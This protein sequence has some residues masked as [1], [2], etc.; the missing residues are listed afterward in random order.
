MNGG[1]G[2]MQNEM[3]SKAKPSVPNVFMSRLGHME[4][5]SPDHAEAWPTYLERLQFYFTA[6]GVVEE[7]HQRVV[8]QLLRSSYLNGAPVSKSSSGE[9]Q[10]AVL[11]QS[12]VVTSVET[13]L[14]DYSDVFKPGLGKSTGLPVR[15]EVEEQATPKFHKSRQVP[16]AL[17]PKVDEAIEKL[18]EQ[19]IYVPI[20]RSRWATPIVPILEER[21]DKNLRRLQGNTQPSCQVEDLPTAH[22]RATAR[23]TGRLFSGRLFSVT[24]HKGLF[25]VT[26]LQ[27]GVAVAVAIFQRYMEGLLNGLEGVQCFLDY[28][29]IGGRTAADHDERLR[30]VLQRNQDDGLRLNADKCAFRDNEVT[31]LGYRINKG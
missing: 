20:K 17:L 15:I 7:K 26:R 28:I 13:P 21:E 19:G 14:G 10:P 27:F 3:T 2:G 8:K 24:T 16:F 25:K 12:K 5:V 30:K 22:S 6:N 1:G 4:D 31:Y 23:K 11:N 18:V 9:S 29:L